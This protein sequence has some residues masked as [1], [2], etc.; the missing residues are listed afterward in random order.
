MNSIDIFSW[1]L[2]IKKIKI[3]CLN[4]AII[5]VVQAWWV[6]KTKISPNKKKVTH[7][8]IGPF[9]HDEKVTHF[10]MES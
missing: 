2:F 8:K 7:K 1:T 9:Q 3:D 5:N 6:T 10:L 4:I